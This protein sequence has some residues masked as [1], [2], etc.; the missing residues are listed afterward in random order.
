MNEFGHF[1]RQA[2]IKAG[3]S[4]GKVAKH[5]GYTTP[6]FVSNWERGLCSP[7]ISTLK[8]LSKIYG[9]E[10]HNFY[11]IYLQVKIS[12]IEAEIKEKLFGKKK[13]KKGK[14]SSQDSS[15]T[16]RPDQKS[17]EENRR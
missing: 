3:L 9:I 6:Q 13:V 17:Q 7:P 2:R 14:I 4:Q 11:D 10:I 15:L 8:R 1:L 12:E 16:P 5:L